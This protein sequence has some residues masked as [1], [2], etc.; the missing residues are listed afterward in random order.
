MTTVGML[1]ARPMNLFRAE[2]AELYERHKCRHSQFGIN[3]GHIIAVYLTWLA[4]Y[5]IATW[6]LSLVSA[7]PWVLPALA[8]LYLAV[9]AP[10]V[11]LRVLILTALFVVL[12]LGTNLLLADVPVWVDVLVIPAAYKLQ[13][14]SHKVWNIERDMTDFNLKYPKGRLL[15]VILTIYE[16]PILLNYLCFDRRSWCYAP[17]GC[18]PLLLA[19]TIFSVFEKIGNSVSANSRR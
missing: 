6:L 18:H 16:A 1:S 4:L 15:F 8:G 13:A 2:F 14:W 3:V 7:P 11:S 5:G 12:L 10:N 17:S 19:E 9:I